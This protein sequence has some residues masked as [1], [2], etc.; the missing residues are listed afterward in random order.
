VPD[1]RLIKFAKERRDSLKKRN[2]KNTAL[3]TIASPRIS[4]FGFEHEPHIVKA[5]DDH[6]QT[7]SA[8]PPSDS[9]SLTPLVPRPERPSFFRS[10][11]GKTS[12]RSSHRSCPRTPKDALHDHPSVSPSPATAERS[13]TPTSIIHNFFTLKKKPSEPISLT[14]METAQL[15]R[16]RRRG[17]ASASSDSPTSLKDGWLKRTQPVPVHR[18]PSDQ[19]SA[20]SPMDT[21]ER[22]LNN[23]AANQTR[24]TTTTMTQSYLAG[25][26]RRIGTPPSPPMKSSK[27]T[28]MTGYF[29]DMGAASY[30]ASQGNELRSAF[31]I[32]PLPLCATTTTHSDT[33]TTEK[34]WYRVRLDQIM[35]EDD[36]YDSEELGIF[37]WDIPEHLPSSPLCPL[38]PKHRGGGKGICVYHGRGL[39]KGKSRRTD[40]DLWK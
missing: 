27:A 16:S 10:F 24:F 37:E 23:P 4:S 35:D 30:E 32:P 6:A 19:S 17:I 31:T 13:T 18:L 39:N 12:S 15:A 1:T 29:W 28:R 5:P 21:S 38:N 25:E 7:P 9:P 36:V 2:K 11:G 3:P 40:A 14:R 26:A 33:S 8:P 20:Y 22:A 34:D